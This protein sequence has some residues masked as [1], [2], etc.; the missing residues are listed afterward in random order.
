[1]LREAVEQHVPGLIG[2]SVDKIK[3]SLPIGR[4]RLYL[5]NG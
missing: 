2:A 3:L 1:M 4:R 5:L